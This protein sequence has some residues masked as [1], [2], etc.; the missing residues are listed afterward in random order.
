MDIPEH[1]NFQETEIDWKVAN[2]CIVRASRRY[3]IHPLVIKAVMLT[4]GGKLGTVMKNTNHTYDLGPMQVNSSNIPY[5]KKTFP[6]IT[7]ERLAN[8]ACA[9][10]IVGTY[11]LKTKI[12]DAGSFWRGV[13]NYHSKTPKHHKKY[14]ARLLP[15][16]RRLAENSRRK[17]DALRSKARVY[18]IR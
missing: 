18:T 16:Y 8:D 15:I 5:L 10:I 7:F 4:E 11:F 17:I 12:D 1:I 13:G 14:M 2:H 3:K 6:T 9:N